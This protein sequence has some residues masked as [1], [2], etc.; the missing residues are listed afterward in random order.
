MS[1]LLAISD[2]AEH[3]S[4][5]CFKTGPPRRIGVELE[6]TVHPTES[7]HTPLDLDRLREALGPHAPATLGNPTPEKLPGGGTVTVEPGGQVELSS[8]PAATLADLH[9][10]VEEGRAH[11]AGRLAR[12]GLALGDAGLDPHRPPRRLLHTPRYG[13][14]QRLFDR[15]GDHGRIMMCSTAGLQVC[16]DAGRPEDVARRWAAVHE[17]GPPLL[18]AFATSRFR[19]GRDTGWASGRMAAWFS[20]EP[21]LT[22]PVGTGADP[23]RLWAAYALAAPL[24][25]LRRDDGDWDAPPGLT[26]AGWIRGR[27]PR[28]PTV[29][30]LE[31]H[32]GTLFPPVRPRG[33]LEIRYLDAQPGDE[34]IAPAAVLAALLDDAVLDRARDLAAPARDRWLDAAREGLAHPEIGTAASHLLDL[35]CRHL[36]RTGLPAHLRDRVAGIAGRRLSAQHRKEPQT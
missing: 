12:S 3:V 29:E 35:A 10:A 26:F 5:I 11:L 24:L 8:A 36:Y 2:A 32:L 1:E 20:M 30:D 14:M 22:R 6:W 15:R 18:A 13:A 34:W 21:G 16:L 27:L 28:P 7:P 23:A 4:G 31:Y 19:A 33:Y 17:L 9:T 25:C